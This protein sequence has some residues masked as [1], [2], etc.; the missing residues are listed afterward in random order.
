MAILN[1]FSSY[2][3]QFCPCSEH[4]YSSCHSYQIDPTFLLQGA[5]G[6]EF[7]LEF[8]P[9]PEMFSSQVITQNILKLL[10]Q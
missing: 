7:G 3:S 6:E 5:A 2:S 8:I 10:D 9:I 1:L 4:F